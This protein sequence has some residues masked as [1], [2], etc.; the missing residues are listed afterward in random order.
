MPPT[1][2]ESP[3]RTEQRLKLLCLIE[4]Y[5]CESENDW[6]REIP[7]HVLVWEGSI[8]ERAIFLL[9]TA[10]QPT[11]VAGEW[12]YLNI[13]QDVG[14]LLNDL[15]DY[16]LV[17]KCVLQDVHGLPTTAYQL[18]E[19]GRGYMKSVPLQLTK[20]VNDLVTHTD[21]W[22]LQV[23]WSKV[24][25][26]FSLGTKVTPFIRA[27]SV[28][29][30]TCIPIAS[31][32]YL[33][34]ITPT[35]PTEVPTRINTL[36]PL[37]VERGE[38]H[39]SQVRVTIAEWQ[40]YGPD[41]VH[42]TANRFSTS[43]EKDANH[44][45]EAFVVTNEP[46]S[47]SSLV[48]NTHA[49]FV[50]NSQLLKMRVKAHPKCLAMHV[51]ASADPEVAQVEVA[52]ALNPSG[53]VIYGAALESS[54][55]IQREYV[56]SLA[57]P[58]FLKEVFTAG[59]RALEHL[60]DSL[61]QDLRD[62]LYNSGG[63]EN[64]DQDRA[65]SAFRSHRFVLV[66]AKSCTP[67][68]CAEDV[69]NQGWTE[70]G[71]K[72]D[73]TRVVGTPESAHDLD[74]FASE[75][76][77]PGAMLVRG[78]DGLFLIGEDLRDLEAMCEEH[79]QAMAMQGS[80]DAL[81]G[82]LHACLDTFKEAEAVIQLYSTSPHT[83]SA[84]KLLEPIRSIEAE[85]PVLLC[86]QHR[87]AD[88]LSSR[89]LVSPSPLDPRARRLYQILGT[90]FIYSDMRERAAQL[91]ERLET[92]L[93]QAAS[94]KPERLAAMIR[95]A[96]I[97]RTTGVVK[98]MSQAHAA[99][100]VQH[101]HNAGIMQVTAVLMAGIFA[102]AA[103]DRVTGPDWTILGAGAYGEGLKDMVEE[104]GI[105]LILSLLLWMMISVMAYRSSKKE[106]ILGAHGSIS[107]PVSGLGSSALEVRAKTNAAVDVVALS[108]YLK[109][110]RDVYEDTVLDDDAVSGRV[111]KRRI[112]WTET[113]GES[114]EDTCLS[115]ITGGAEDPFKEIWD[116]VSCSE[117]KV[118]LQI[119]MHRSTLTELRLVLDN[120][121]TGAQG[122][123]YVEKTAKELY[124]A[125][126]L[127]TPP[128]IHGSGRGNFLRGA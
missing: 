6:L 20:T 7:L 85:L 32:P 9:P 76:G 39:F 110:K 108:D 122:S 111:Y 69:L 126:V 54:A 4:R 123:I 35:K 120:S 119:D 99:T 12:F 30:I 117:W 105:W 101:R 44:G 55:S 112:Q 11:R 37:D 70:G 62:A 87:L 15:D 93:Q 75:S 77:S 82:R 3:L 78:R 83:I 113:R 79:I 128:H 53:S 67:E 81:E 13:A 116:Q 23:R 59:S 109:W 52:I 24:R 28:T 47:E 88:A 51:E 91:G 25:G 31:S 56:H 107:R 43:L 71:A 60:L 61:S 41:W 40:P 80:C 90:R 94:L 29:E 127:S 34:L 96:Q 118:L 100:R 46:I 8:H 89:G 18:T 102:F 95:A 121:H 5:C 1:A 65:K 33:S 64:Q 38:R 106:Q 16:G 68:V 73:I 17:R 26:S 97:E 84:S 10:P 22:R 21:G 14:D 125:N 42:M 124:E 27:S 72:V 50:S 57:V 36:A 104:P 115:V 66:L 103:C 49:R 92:A 45:D 114:A 58:I 98:A 48:V 63:G 74:I 19:S 2:G 86:V